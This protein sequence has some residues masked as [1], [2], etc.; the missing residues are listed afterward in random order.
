MN[1]YRKG[2]NVEEELTKD[3]IPI[4]NLQ[5]NFLWMHVK[6]GTK[7]SNVVDYAKKALDNNEYRQVVWSGSGG[8]SRLLFLMFCPFPSLL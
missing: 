7:V 2:T 6:G 1:N 4:E 5:E 8:K 3:C